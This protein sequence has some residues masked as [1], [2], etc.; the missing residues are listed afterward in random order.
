RRRIA[1]VAIA[2]AVEEALHH[3]MR[4]QYDA[5]EVEFLRRLRTAKPVE[6]QTRDV[7]RDDAHSKHGDLALQEPARD[8]DRPD[9]RGDVERDLHGLR[10][11][12]RE[13]FVAYHQRD[14]SSVLNA[15]VGANRAK[16]VAELVALLDGPA[17][18][19]QSAGLNGQHLVAYDEISR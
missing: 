19:A 2:V 12:V 14:P 6:H 10:E 17:L 7:A 8:R 3:L 13:R 5:W 18:T 15:G 11:L 16:R 9:V 1:T 4:A